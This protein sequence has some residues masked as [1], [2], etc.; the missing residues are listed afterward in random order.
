MSEDIRN[1]IVDLVRISVR[2]LEEMTRHLKDFTENT[3]FA[4]KDR[5]PLSDARYWPS[6]SAVLN[7][8]YRAQMNTR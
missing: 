7:C 8:M 4:G 2:S 5:P 3:L 6:F 1:K